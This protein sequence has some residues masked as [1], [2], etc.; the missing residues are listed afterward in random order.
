MAN[1]IELS[2]HITGYHEYQAEWVPTVGEILLGERE[3]DNFEDHHAVCVRKDG[4]VVGH[5]ERGVSGRF[6]QLIFFF[7]RA[8][9]NARCTVTITGQP[10]N[11]GDMLGMKV[12]CKIVLT[13]G[14]E[15]MRI[16][17]TQLAQLNM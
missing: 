9:R 11:L 1:F 2:S 6:A 15:Y 12:P 8:D 14:Q 16:S 5:L 10:V 17:D 4:R 7:L 3:P 13:G